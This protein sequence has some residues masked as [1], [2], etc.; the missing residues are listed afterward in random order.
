MT[1]SICLRRRLSVARILFRRAS[2][3]KAITLGGAL[4]FHNDDQLREATGVIDK[5]EKEE[6]EKDPS[7]EGAHNL[8]SYPSLELS[9]P[10]S[11]SKKLKRF[12]SSASEGFLLNIGH[13]N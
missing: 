4:I 3:A 10:L 2:E 11:T 9:M 5:A 13:H 12:A 8:L 7:H 6:T 1:R